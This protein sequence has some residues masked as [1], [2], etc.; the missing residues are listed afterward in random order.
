MR[1]TRFAGLFLFL[2]ILVGCSTPSVYNLYETHKSDPNLEHTQISGELL[3]LGS[4][5]IP[6]SEKASLRLLKAVSSVDIVE[7]D[8]HKS[9]EFHK[10]FL[11]SLNKGGYKKI[12]REGQ[13]F[14]V[15]KRL[16]KVKEFHTFT[17]HNGILTVFSVNG[18]FSV[19]DLEK[20]YRLIKKQRNLKSF[21]NN[22]RAN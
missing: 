16:T 3:N 21:M 19:F 22:L 4:F 15:K 17:E 18:N 20:A 8:S 6:R 13:T 1:I 9:A 7:Y 11:H 5:L 2:L 12:E 14:Y 10:Q